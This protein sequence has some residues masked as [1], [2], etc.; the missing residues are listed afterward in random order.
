M[1]YCILK[2]QILLLGYSKGKIKETN[3]KIVQI[4][5]A[6]QFNT[7]NFSRDVRGTLGN[8]GRPFPN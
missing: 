3:N 4:Y 6:I 5:F 2:S 8:L 7:T 1:F